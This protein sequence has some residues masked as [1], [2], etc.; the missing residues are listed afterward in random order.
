MEILKLKLKT[1]KR[2]EGLR[3]GRELC[4]KKKERI[5]RI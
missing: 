4:S 3:C 1:D 2:T 5:E